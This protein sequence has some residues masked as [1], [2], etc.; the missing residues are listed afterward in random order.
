MASTL[1]Q[2]WL[3]IFLSKSSK[4]CIVRTIRFCS[5]STSMWSKYLSNNVWR[6]F[7]LPMSASEMVYNIKYPIEKSIFALNLPLKLSPATIANADIGSQISLHTLFDKYLD[8]TLVKFKQ[9]R[10]VQTTRNFKLFDR[11]PGFLKLFLTTRW[12]HFGRCFCS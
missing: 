8:H 10:M 11:K 3:T 5:N 4:F 12:R 7:R 6:N 1:C 9:N 2:K